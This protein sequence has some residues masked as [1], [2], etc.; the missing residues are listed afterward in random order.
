MR[1]ARTPLLT[2]LRSDNSPPVALRNSLDSM[3]E[4]THRDSKST[5]PAVS[6][7][8]SKLRRLSREAPT[9]Q[10]I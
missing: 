9:F 8:S 10:E 1:M 7:P 5:S 2:A 4:D 3:A 6:P